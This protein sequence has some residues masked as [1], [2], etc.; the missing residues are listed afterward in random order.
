MKRVVLLPVFDDWL[1][2]E[3][4]L[5]RL[6]DVLLGQ[7][8]A[9][10]VLFVDDGSNV[11]IPSG[12]GSKGPLPG[13][14]SLL[15]LR[16]NLGHE[17]AIAVGLA[18]LHAKGGYDEMVI[19]DADGE[20]DPCDVPGLIARLGGRREPLVVFAARARRSEGILFRLGYLAYRT[21][22]R[23]LT[24]LSIRFGS[25]SLLNAAALGRLVATSEMWNHYAAA[26]VKSRLPYELVATRR[27]RRLAG[28]S[29]MNVPALVIH[30]LSALSVYSEV[31]GVRVLFF[32]GALIV[33][34]ASSLAGVI[35]VRLLTAAAI[36]GWASTVAG[37]ILVLMAQAFLLLVGGVFF[38]LQAR[39]GFSVIPSR[40]HVHFILDHRVLRAEP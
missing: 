1:A 37:L 36:P 25:F 29:T 35:G 20:D 17:R 5:A 9:A 30:G 33:L 11:P 27:G 10:D 2:A 40:D 15:R 8:I 34:L 6:A 23:L 38:V 26:V 28:S 31:M 19:M 32:L 39:S 22:H 3:A 13:T 12:F 14:L 18:F 4:L 16:R 7:G 21:L 24:G